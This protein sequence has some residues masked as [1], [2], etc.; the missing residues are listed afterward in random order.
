[1]TNTYERVTNSINVATNLKIETEGSNPSLAISKLDFYL[2]ETVKYDLTN[3]VN[4]NGTVLDKSS[5]KIVSFKT[6]ANIDSA[7]INNGVLSITGKTGISSLLYNP[8]WIKI[9]LTG[10]DA[11]VIQIDT[12]PLPPRNA[13]NHGTHEFEIGKNIEITQFDIMAMNLNYNSNV[14][15]IANGYSAHLPDGL[16]INSTDGNIT[17][18]LSED[19]IGEFYGEY[20]ISTD[21]GNIIC[22]LQIIGNVSPPLLTIDSNTISLS[23]LNDGNISLEDFNTG[24]PGDFYI[25]AGTVLSDNNINLLEYTGHLKAIPNKV[26]KKEVDIIVKNRNIFVTHPN[27]GTNKAHLPIGTVIEN[28]DSGNVMCFPLEYGYRGNINSLPDGGNIIG[29]KFESEINTYSQTIHIEVFNEPLDLLHNS[30]YNQTGNISILTPGENIF[31]INDY[32]TNVGGVMNQYE[33][34][35]NSG[36]VNAL[37]DLPNTKLSIDENTG[38]ITI[39]PDKNFEPGRIDEFTVKIKNRPD[40]DG[41]TD[42]SE[43]SF[44]ITSESRLYL[45]CGD[46]LNLQIDRITETACLQVVSSILDGDNP[47]SIDNTIPAGLVFNTGTSVITGTPTELGTTQITFNAKV[48]T[49]TGNISAPITINIVKDVPN[50]VIEN[51]TLQISQKNSEPKSLRTYNE[52]GVIEN[53]EFIEGAQINNVGINGSTSNFLPYSSFDTV[54]PK[55]WHNYYSSYGSKRVAINKNATIMVFMDSANTNLKTAIR[56]N[57]TWTSVDSATI[58]YEHRAFYVDISANDPTDEVSP[59]I[60]LARDD[61]HTVSVYDWNNSNKTW[62]KYGDI[63]LSGHNFSTCNISADGSSILIGSPDGS[64]M[65]LYIDNDTQFENDSSYTN[66]DV[67]NSLHGASLQLNKVESSNLIVASSPVSSNTGGESFVHEWVDASTKK[68]IIRYP[69]DHSKCGWSIAMSKSPTK[70]GTRLIIGVPGVSSEGG[71]HAIVMERLSSASWIMVGNPLAR[72]NYTLPNPPTSV[73]SNSDGKYTDYERAGYSVSISDDG[74]MVAVGC[75]GYN[76][77]GDRGGRVRFYEYDQNTLDWVEHATQIV[78]E[79]DNDELGH[80]IEMSGNGEYITVALKNDTKVYKVTRIQKL[81]T[82]LSLDTDSGNIV[83]KAQLP[84]IFPIAMKL[85]NTLNYNKQTQLVDFNI[86]LVESSPEL[87]F[88]HTQLSLELSGEKEVKF[89]R[90]YLVNDGGK[91]TEYQAT[92]NL[93]GGSYGID[94]VTGKLTT[95]LPTDLN[96]SVDYYL[97]IKGVNGAGQSSA[98]ISVIPAIAFGAVK[99]HSLYTKE[100]VE[101]VHFELEEYSRIDASLISQFTA[102]N[103]PQGLQMNSESGNISGT[104]STDSIGLHYVTVYGQNK[105]A[106]G[107][108]IGDIQICVD[109]D[110]PNIEIPQSTSGNLVGDVINFSRNL[111]GNVSS[112]EYATSSGGFVQHWSISCDN[113]IGNLIDN[114]PTIQP[115]Q[116]VAPKL[117]DFKSGAGHKYSAGDGTVTGSEKSKSEGSDIQKD[118]EFTFWSDRV[119]T[120]AISSQHTFDNTYTDARVGPTLSEAKN[121]YGSGDEWWHNEDYYTVINNKDESDWKKGGGIQIWTV[122]QNGIYTIEAQGASGGANN[123]GGGTEQAYGWDWSN[124]GGG[125]GG[126]GARIWADFD[127]K[128]GDKIAILVGQSGQPGSAQNWSNSDGGGG[129]GSFVIKYRE[130]NT[131]YTNDDILMI[132]AGGGGSSQYNRPEKNAISWTDSGISAIHYAPNGSNPY[133]NGLILGD[134]TSYYTSEFKHYGHGSSQLSSGEHAN[135]SSKYGYHSSGTTSGP[136]GG[137]LKYDPNTN[138][139]SS[140]WSPEWTKTSS[141]SGSYTNGGDVYGKSFEDG[142]YGGNMGYITAGGFGGGGGGHGQDCSNGGGGGGYIGGA[143][144]GAWRSCGSGYGGTSYVNKLKVASDTTNYNFDEAVVDFGFSNSQKYSE[145]WTGSNSTSGTKQYNNGRVII[146][147]KQP[148]TINI[149]PV[150]D[151]DNYRTELPEGLAVDSKTGIISGKAE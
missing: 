54:D 11:D 86:Q 29:A 125:Y 22:P 106:L 78:G 138:P 13:L 75:P 117:Y 121:N 130:D 131:D 35:S 12:Y 38:K 92:S 63:S 114:D 142:G 133:G 119:F 98:N 18:S 64:T 69:N 20:I 143:T 41:S 50:L 94:E 85:S 147:L 129:G 14:N 79:K 126:S 26:Q 48:T 74:N 87:S 62:E 17:G 23:E 80:N 102:D 46:S 88:K 72:S 105:D 31:N 76:G 82:G 57:T 33:I 116:V 136:G 21:K 140:G 91:I 81:P 109:V 1:M 148:E 97:D 101:N 108:T 139:L 43:I 36:N 71:G 128:K 6:L 93:P 66:T 28:G 123:Q 110:T 39:V 73:G 137:Y 84:G 103:L 134:N 124:N 16:N 122:P 144:S 83:G 132:A 113:N 115:I 49:G 42:E 149:Q 51:N 111:F 99:N 68:E 59:R 55:Q 100:R 9:S 2:G 61:N 65:D 120:I 10:V 104:P 135:V 25:E 112:S 24:S 30:T 27:D 77:N 32:I 60:V 37:G 70:K 56:T 44:N 107:N 53:F 52:G 118:N 4:N 15:T 96:T 127:L 95:T 151:P 5:F 145:T 47:F 8:S 90:N 150:I 45:P 40:F 141:H 34:E 19:Y 58:D 7:I 3:Y 67:S 89:A 146:K